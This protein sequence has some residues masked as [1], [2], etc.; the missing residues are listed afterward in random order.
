MAATSNT[1][2]VAQDISSP[3]PL[4]YNF[5]HQFNLNDP[6]EARHTYQRIMHEHTKQQFQI[7]TQSSRRRG[8]PTDH[9]M[10]GL[11]SESSN[12]S[13]DSSDIQS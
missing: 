1:I 4:Q 11:Y 9:P 12:E 7:A 2:Y 6:E 13:V 10:S 5:S 3:T 8:S